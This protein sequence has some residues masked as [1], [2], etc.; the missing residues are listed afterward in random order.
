M[1]GNGER[2]Q[3]ACEWRGWE[4]VT[5]AQKRGKCDSCESPWTTKFSVSVDDSLSLSFAPLIYY[6]QIYHSKTRAN[7]SDVIS[8]HHCSSF[9]LFGEDFCCCPSADRAAINCVFRLCRSVMS[10]IIAAA[11]SNHRQTKRQRKQRQTGDIRLSL[12]S[13][14]KETPSDH[15]N[16]PEQISI[17]TENALS[18]HCI[19]HEFP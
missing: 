10:G 9:S 7:A 3:P 8:F 11:P 19:Y 16:R 12:S 18:T 1:C 4:L 15:P 5:F 2:S 6:C 14:R 13:T 17:V